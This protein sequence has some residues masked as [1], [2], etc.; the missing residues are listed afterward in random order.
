NGNLIY[1]ETWVP[2]Q[3]RKID[4]HQQVLAEIKARLG[5]LEKT[6]EYH[7]CGIKKCCAEHDKNENRHHE[8]NELIK[9]NQNL[10]VGSDFSSAPNSKQINQEEKK[11]IR[12]YF[13][14]K[15]I[16]S[17]TLDEDKLVIVYNDKSQEIVEVN[18]SQL[19][20]IKK[21]VEKQPNQRLS[22]SELQDKTV[23]S[24]PD[25]SKLYQGLAIGI[26]SGIIL[27]TLALIFASRKKPSSKKS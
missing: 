9:A 6:G 7:N 10:M 23:N 15:K 5:V 8:N 1:L 25:N 13:E 20:Q 12:E 24:S 4:L 11:Q 16:F 22:F 2:E 21:I 17:I 19:R 26:L 3:K 18:N 27:V 14:T